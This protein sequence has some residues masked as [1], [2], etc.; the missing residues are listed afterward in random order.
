MFYHVHKPLEGYIPHMALL[1][2][3]EKGVPLHICA[4]NARLVI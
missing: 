1:Q 3:L 4:L 2:P